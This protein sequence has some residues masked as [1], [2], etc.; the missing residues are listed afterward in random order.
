MGVKSGKGR[1]QGSALQ[2]ARHGVGVVGAGLAQGR[3][4]ALALSHPL[5]CQP[6]AFAAALEQALDRCHPLFQR[7]LRVAQRIGLRL[8]GQALQVLLLDRL[9]QPLHEGLMAAQ[10]VDAGAAPAQCRVALPVVLLIGQQLFALG[11]QAAQLRF[12]AASRG[13]GGVALPFGKL[14][15]G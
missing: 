9:L 4:V 1:Q 12:A 11:L 3:F 6:G 5:A 2:R 13:G 14:Q 10:H 7:Q 8:H 15:Q